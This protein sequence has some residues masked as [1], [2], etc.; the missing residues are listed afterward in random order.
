M[1]RMIA[2]SSSGSSSAVA[3]EARSSSGV[4]RNF[5]TATRRTGADAAHPALRPGRTLRLAGLTF[6]AVHRHLKRWRN[7]LHERLVDPDPSGAKCAGPDRADPPLVRDR[8]T[9]RPVEMSFKIRALWRG[10][11]GRAFDLQRSAHAD[12]RK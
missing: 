11:N 8:L 7:W 12:S 9:F 2:A 1:L 3:L 6:G 4:L 5:R 10:R